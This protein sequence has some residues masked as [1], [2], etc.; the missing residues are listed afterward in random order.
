ML[1]ESRNFGTR[2]GNAGM[3]LNP[4]EPD[5]MVELRPDDVVPNLG[6]IAICKSE[7]GCC[8][9]NSV[10]RLTIF[11][12]GDGTRVTHWEMIAEFA[13]DDDAGDYLKWRREQE[14]GSRSQ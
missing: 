8:Y 7:H 4:V 14:A 10:R 5:D 12:R 11:E 1:P 9:N 13:E 3:L 6:E 2:K